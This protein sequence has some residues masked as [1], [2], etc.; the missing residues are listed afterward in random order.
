M[1]SDLISS[2]EL[3]TALLTLFGAVLTFILNRAAGA[4]Q[5][6]TGIRIEEK[7]QRALH[8]AMMSGAKAALRFG[9]EHGAD[10]LKRLTLDYAQRSV[11][12]AIRARTQSG[13]S[14][15]WLHTN[16]RPTITTSWSSARAA[17]ACAPRSAW[18][19]RACAP[20]A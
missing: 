19:N 20:L 6:A 9:P 16:L 10:V 11:P 14:D 5:A 12:D 17:R 8:S 18:P 15:T 3:Q 1:F 13:A 2:P 7:H 4:F